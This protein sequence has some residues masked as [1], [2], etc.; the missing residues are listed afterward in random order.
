MVT[1]K[2]SGTP[3]QAIPPLL[4]DGVTTITPEI[5]PF[6]LFTPVKLIFPEPV[7]FKPMAALEFVQLYTVPAMLFGE[8]NVTATC[9]PA[10]TCWFC[11]GATVGNGFTVMV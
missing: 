11:V 3:G 1:R 6:V 8:V 10:Q 9:V 4:K 2:V 5:G 7:P